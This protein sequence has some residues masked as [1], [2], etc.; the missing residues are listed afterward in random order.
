MSPHDPYTGAWGSA[1]VPM[2]PCMLFAKSWCMPLV[3]VSS[4]IKRREGMDKSMGKS[5]TMSRSTM[6]ANCTSGSRS[7]SAKGWGRPPGKSRGR[8]NCAHT[9]E[10]PAELLGDWAFKAQFCK[11]EAKQRCPT[12]IQTVGGNASILCHA[13][14]ILKPTDAS[15]GW[16]LCSCSETPFGGA[17]QSQQYTE[18][19]WR[20][21]SHYPRASMCKYFVFN[22]Q[23]C[24]PL[25]SWSL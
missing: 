23:H 2:N 3:A 18:D 13:A 4:V 25:L 6:Q 5:M 22:V 16:G 15:W 21:L 1:E 17:C 11:W 9:A 10:F 7:A 12:A 20:S 14:F 24:C 19:A 8:R